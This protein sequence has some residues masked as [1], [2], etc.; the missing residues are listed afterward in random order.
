MAKNIKHLPTLGHRD[1]SFSSSREQTPFAPIP[2]QPRTRRGPLSVTRVGVNC[3][4]SLTAQPF[5]MR[6]S[7]V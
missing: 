6:C 5:P 1:L 4:A 3:I 2:T 7:E